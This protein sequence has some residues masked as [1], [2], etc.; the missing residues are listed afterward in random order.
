MLTNTPVDDGSPDTPV[1]SAV[2]YF[3]L[4]SENRSSPDVSRNQNYDPWSIFDTLTRAQGS[5]YNLCSLSNPNKLQKTKKAE[6]HAERRCTGIWKSTHTSDL[7]LRLD[8]RLS[9][10]AEI[11]A[12][13]PLQQSLPW[14]WPGVYY[15]V[16]CHER[17]GRE[18]G[19]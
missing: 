13:H 16:M 7:L 18:D 17:R 8:K 11:C 12:C 1:G 9:I 14:L 6:T 19:G 15:Q 2:L 3:Q 10:T 5:S 4:C